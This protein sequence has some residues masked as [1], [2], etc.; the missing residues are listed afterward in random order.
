M[1]GVPSGT[2]AYY[3]FDFGNIHFICLNSYDVDRA[4][5]STMLTWL[6]HDLMNTVQDWTVAFWHHPPY[7]KGSHDSD[8]EGRMSD[9][10]ENAL[11]ILE[12][13]GVDLVLSG[14]SHSYERSYLLDSHYE[15]SNTLTEAMVA[16]SGDGRIDGNGSYNKPTAGP[17]THEGAVYV[18]AGSSGKAGP[19]PLDHPAMYRSVQVLGSLVLDIEGDRLEAKFIDDQGTLRDYFTIAKG[20]AGRPHADFECSPTSGSPPL[21][22]SCSDLSA[23]NV[24]SWDW[25]FD[26]DGLSDSTEQNPTRVYSSGGSYT[27]RLT[28]TNA[29]GADTR[30]RI[31]HIVVSSAQQPPDPPTGL[32]FVP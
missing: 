8:S 30:T 27:V 28:V 12:D 1:G 4:P 3:S 23:P 18:V 10:R 7:S 32:R 20:A 2:E 19:G 24:A 29:S 31:D 21:N 17:A 14:H 16:D 9:M 22:V 25:D 15:T 13:W 11:P 6:E 5:G 26:G